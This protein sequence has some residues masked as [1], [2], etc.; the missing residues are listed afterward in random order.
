[1]ADPPPLKVDPNALTW[2]PAVV[3]VPPVPVIPAGGDPMSA[4]ISA[5]MP[6]IATELTTAVANTHA[7]EQQFAANLTSARAAYQSTDQSGG[8]EIQTVA[9]TQLA[10]STTAPAASGGGGA[11]SQFG[12]LMSTAMQIGGQV[13]QAPAQ[14]AGMVAAAPQAVMQ[15]AQGAVQQISQ[16]AGQFEKPEGDA[17]AVPPVDQ[18]L[19]LD[20][21]SIDAE[22]QPPA[23]EGADAGASAVER[24]PEQT[25]EDDERE[26]EEDRPNPIDL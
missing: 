4:L 6:G 22:Q 23:E 7:R 24:A 20:G 26:R 25:S 18:A 13:A 21:G 14:L 11:G 8:E 17:A 2:D 15:G 3:N 5:V 10:P 12:Q 16:V 1:M 19:G 9:N